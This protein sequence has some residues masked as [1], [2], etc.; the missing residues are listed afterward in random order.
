MPQAPM[1]VPTA[2]ATQKNVV[3][4]PL[5]T[6]KRGVTVKGYTT[7]EIGPG[8]VLG[9]ITASGKFAPYAAGNGDGTNL[10]RCILLNFAPN[11]GLDHVLEV[12][13]SG[14]LVLDQL[15]GLD[16]GAVT[17]LGAVEDTAFNSFRF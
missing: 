16:A 5:M 14:V 3:Q 17:Q 15:V 12:A 2:Q 4:S 8:Q 1:I 6:V 10:A 7:A 13:I 11:D 9:M